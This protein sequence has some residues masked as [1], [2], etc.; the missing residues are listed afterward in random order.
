[1]SEPSEIRSES[2]ADIMSHVSRALGFEWFLCPEQ[3]GGRL[4]PKISVSASP[5]L[6]KVTLNV[7]F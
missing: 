1:M 6:N 4:S 7:S 2:D 3:D 5:A